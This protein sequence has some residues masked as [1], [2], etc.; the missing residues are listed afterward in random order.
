MTRSLASDVFA[1]T[2]EHVWLVF[3]SVSLAVALAVPGG[4]VLTRRARLRRWLLGFANVVQTI[5]SLA[6]F[7]FLDRRFGAICATPCAAKHAGGDPWD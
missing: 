4:L 5:P 1:L 3:I 2:L 7:G 6:V